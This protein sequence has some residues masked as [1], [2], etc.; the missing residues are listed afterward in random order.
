M[1]SFHLVQTIIFIFGMCTG[2]FV[3]VCIYRLPASKSIIDP[4]RSICPNCGSI[5]R[6]YDNIPVL[7]YLWLKGRCRNCNKPIS[8][9]YPLVE[10]ISGVFALCTFLKFG[11]TLEALVYFAF[12]TALVVI[13]FIDIDHQ[14]IPDLITIPG[15][16]VCFLASFALPSITYK[17]SLLGLFAG[18]G[19]LLLVGWI[20]YLIKRAEGM[21]GGD[22]KL[23]A[24]I[25]A[26]VG[27]KGV[28]FTIFVSS[29]VGTLVGITIMLRTKKGMKIAVPFGPFL[30]IGAMTYIFFGPGLIFWYFNLLR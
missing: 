20:Y 1:F 26:M 22:I 25:G 8:F 4:R 6:F 16:P 21:G 11:P 18:G 12:I 2:S 9:R 10:I 17:E 23:M 5:I 28:L 3:N 15:I 19:S 24:M 27:W 29:L 7:S 13:T 30:S 14:I